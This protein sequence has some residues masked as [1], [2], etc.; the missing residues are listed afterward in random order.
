MTQQILQ[1]GGV[2]LRGLRLLGLELSFHLDARGRV[3]FPLS[4]GSHVVYGRNGVGKST[5]LKAL[6]A[7][8][9]SELSED[10][11]GF[12]VRLFVEFSD[13]PIESSSTTFFDDISVLTELRDDLE[14]QEDDDS[15]DEDNLR[16]D[17]SLDDDDFDTEVISTAEDELTIRQDTIVSRMELVH[18]IS[19]GQWWTDGDSPVWQ[20]PE[21]F[22]QVM[23]SLAD[24][25][26]AL[27]E[28]QCVE[29]WTESYGV[30]LRQA[31]TAW[32]AYHF[33][34]REAMHDGE[35]NRPGEKEI[36]ALLREGV[37][38]EIYCLRPIGN[39]EWSLSCAVSAGS[40]VASAAVK[41]L[42]ADLE[43]K[44]Q[45][46]H[47]E[48][49][50]WPDSRIQSGEV[51]NVFITET[52]ESEFINNLGPLPGLVGYDENPWNQWRGETN[53][54]PY[55]ELQDWRK[56]PSVKWRFLSGETSY[57]AK[58]E[59]SV[60][61]LDKTLDLSKWNQSKIASCFEPSRNSNG[62]VFSIAEEVKE[63]TK[64]HV[65]NPQN[66]LEPVTTELYISQTEINSS[67]A[68]ERLEQY[69][70]L[71]AEIGEVLTSFGIGLDGVRTRLSTDISDWV[72]GKG[73]SLEVRSSVTASW[74]SVSALSPAQTVIL[75][76]VLRIRDA[77]EKSNFIFCIG[78]ETD[79]GLHVAAIRNLYKFLLEESDVSYLTSHSPVVLSLPSHRRM[80]VTNTQLS[81]L[82]VKD[83][84]PEA[85]FSGAADVL[86]LDKVHLL[87]A[88]T[89][90]IIVEGEHDVAAF[91]VL[92]DD[93]RNFKSLIKVLPARGHMNTMNVLNCEAVINYS[94]APIVVVV[95]GSAEID[96]PKIQ[97]VIHQMI[98][99]GATPQTILSKAIK[100]LSSSRH[101]PETRTL[102]SILTE[103]VLR[104]QHDRIH[105][106]ELDQRDI[107]QYLSPLHFGVSGTWQT[108]W[109]EYQTSK[110]KSSFK[111][112]LQLEYGADISTNTVRNGF[113][114]LDNYSAS[115][116][117]VISRISDL[118]L[119]NLSH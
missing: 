22:Q 55:L 111:E 71:L 19:Q 43:A 27:R 79:A 82:V 1:E 92:L 17:E 26:S 10:D 62:W 59:M 38:D 115:L 21:L 98:Q 103:A 89:C 84:K 64:Y 91:D 108:L 56:S 34:L 113:Q 47:R 7:A 73:C 87:S 45:K 23:E 109:T 70:V 25:D 68:S 11:L 41:L 37:R 48:A 86:G 74:F 112:W 99:E 102:L 90:W 6:H 75:A 100:P 119:G 65:S 9:T 57:R 66:L 72:N 118:S 5:L 116:S 76:T 96:F 3:W 106:I 58:Q 63:K 31:R 53:E 114:T 36:K 29:L 28:D 81:P 77:R 18:A 61:E 93:P 35:E 16:D 44:R 42:K 32:L 50:N 12:N 78:D 20:E 107:I 39:G 60:V 14:D 105:L 83:W 110:T 94:D 80:L 49:L 46:F 117:L 2:A 67:F 24:E 40:A 33:L 52:Y 104:G 69:H 13:E 51:D 88:I 101:L 54:C 15:L 85:N 4:P 97:S 95:D 30:R 8:L